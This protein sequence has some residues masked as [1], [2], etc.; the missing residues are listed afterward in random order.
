MPGPAP[1]PG[2]IRGQILCS[3]KGPAHRGQ[4]PRTVGYNKGEFTYGDRH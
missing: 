3:Q 2:D 4:R 1:G